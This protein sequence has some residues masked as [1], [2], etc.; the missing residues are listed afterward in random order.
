MDVI[1]C[2]TEVNIIGC[3]TEVGVTDCWREVRE[4]GCSMSLAILA[5]KN[6]KS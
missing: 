4:A 2:C 3:C 6:P 1:G 5:S